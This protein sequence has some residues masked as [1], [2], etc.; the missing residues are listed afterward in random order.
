MLE[1]ILLIMFIGFAFVGFIAV[2]LISFIYCF[3]TYC[4]WSHKKAKNERD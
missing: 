2:A 3:Q 1:T 4:E